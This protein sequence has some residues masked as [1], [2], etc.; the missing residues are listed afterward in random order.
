ML[1]SVS[2]QIEEIIRRQKENQD[3]LNSICVEQ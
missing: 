1:A 2:Q 3:V